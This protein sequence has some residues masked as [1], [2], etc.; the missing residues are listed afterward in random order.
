MPNRTVI[1]NK[2]ITTSDM[3]GA[4]DLLCPRCGAD[5]LHHGAVNRYDRAEDGAEAPYN[6]AEGN[7]SARRGGLTVDFECEGC[8]D[9]IQ[10]TLAQHKGSTEI[11]WRYTPTGVR[12]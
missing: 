5:N 11:G 9:G 4:T 12:T 8:G 1:I 7:P 3:G 10:L 2:T 6:R